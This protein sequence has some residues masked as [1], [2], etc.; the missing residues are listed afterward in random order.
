MKFLLGHSRSYTLP[1]SYFFSSF[2]SLFSSLPQIPIALCDGPDISLYNNQTAIVNGLEGVSGTL[3][4]C[5]D[6]TL[7]GFCDDGSID[8][9]A[10][11]M[12]CNAL[13]YLCKHNFWFS[14][15]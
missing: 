11:Q 10:A 1:F 7:T 9:G 15:I 13:G 6:G 3:G 8:D 12:F 4:L 14:F 5:Q 2:S